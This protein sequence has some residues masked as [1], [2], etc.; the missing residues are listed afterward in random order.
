MVFMFEDNP[1]TPS[2]ELLCY[3]FPGKYYFSGGSDSVSDKV[4]SI[5]ARCT[6]IIK[7]GIL[8]TTYYD[9]SKMTFLLK[10]IIDESFGFNPASLEKFYKSLM[11]KTKYPC[12]LNRIDQN[13]DYIEA[14]V[15]VRDYCTI[16]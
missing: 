10:D 4:E 15:I 6:E 2:S 12:T 1:T 11:T 3:T 8:T 16:K 7:A 13:K 9:K 14:I 5:L